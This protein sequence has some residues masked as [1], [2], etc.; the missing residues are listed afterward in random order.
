VPFSI[1]S[2]DEQT[3]SE[4]R[5]RFK[6]RNF[7]LGTYF[8]A[9]REPRIM[10]PNT[11]ADDN[12]H[13]HHYYP[14]V[15]ACSHCETLLLSNA[16][17]VLVSRHVG[18][19]MD[20]TTTAAS[21]ALSCFD[22]VNSLSRQIHGDS[23]CG[24]SSVA[25][26]N[27]QHRQQ[28]RSQHQGLLGGGGGDHHG[29]SSSEVVVAPPRMTSSQQQPS[30]AHRPPLV[31]VGHVPIRRDPTTTSTTNSSNTVAAGPAATMMALSSTYSGTTTA[32]NNKSSTSLAD[33]SPQAS[34]E[35]DGGDSTA[36]ISLIQ[37]FDYS[38]FY[39]GGNGMLPA[40][41][42]SSGAN[43]V[44][45]K[46]KGNKTKPTTAGA[47]SKEEDNGKSS[48]GGGLH[49]RETQIFLHGIPTF[50]Q[51]FANVKIGVISAHSLGAHV[52]LIS[53]AGLLYSYG[54]NQRGQLG[55]GVA[56]AA[57]TR[58][59]IVTPLLE[60]GGKAI[61]CAAGAFH[62]LVVVE[63]R[64]GQDQ[65]YGFGRHDVLGLVRPSPHRADVLLPRRVQLR[66]STRIAASRDH[67]AAIH[68]DGSLYV[69]S[70]NDQPM[71]VDLYG[72]RAV[73]VALGPSTTLVVTESG[74]CYSAGSSDCGMLGQGIG[75][76]DAERFVP[77]DIP[78]PVV[79]VSAGVTH[80]VAWTADGA[81]YGWGD[82]VET[83]QTLPMNL[84][85]PIVQAVVGRDCCFYVARNGS[86]L[87]SGR[88]SGRLG[89]G[90]V[91]EEV[92]S[93]RPLYGGLRLWYC[94]D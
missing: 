11:H 80:V 44:T 33:L 46:T 40:A 39:E 71:A 21:M 48:G 45:N 47:T 30:G 75:R 37:S 22:D 87:S 16:G 68:Q 17:D 59:T 3:R 67:S 2:N 76:T 24:A 86:V 92:V 81:V 8:I 42:T 63:N 51:A 38:Q 82:T 15:I 73:D 43:N 85:S 74:T 25:W 84:E 58:P 72:E 32:N 65:L 7:Q 26:E 23:L 13:H 61:A 29:G 78:A 9:D 94:H 69:W 66:G 60:N 19:V 62:S 27:H 5:H 91:R 50:C 20:A 90:D 49:N 54:A 64:H 55:I 83:P 12:H 77:I 70:V 88:P 14:R 57:V 34:A 28:P 6:I 93:P 89:Q 35:E 18:A 1:Q 36:A 31:P 79:G 41:S 53:K 56:G 4:T 10:A 52:L